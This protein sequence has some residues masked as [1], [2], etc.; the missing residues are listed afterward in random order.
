MRRARRAVVLAVGVSALALTAAATAAASA[1][2]T[3]RPGQVTTSPG[4]TTTLA[5]TTVATTTVAPSTT[6]VPTTEPATTTEPVSTTTTTTAQPVTTSDDDTSVPWGWII[7]ILAALAVVLVVVLVFMRRSSNRAKSEW[8]NAAAS[9]LRDADLTRDMLADEARPG[10]AEDARRLH[11]SPRRGR[12]RREPVRP[13]RDERTERRDATDLDLLGDVPSRLFLR[14]GVRADAAR[15]SRAP[16]CRPARHRGRHETS[17]ARLNSR[18]PLLRFVP[19]PSGVIPR[20][21]RTRCDTARRSGGTQP[22]RQARSGARRTPAFRAVRCCVLLR[23]RRRRSD[24]RH[25]SR[26]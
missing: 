2:H 20:R 1:M 17:P 12:A 23:R 7:A 4:E 9:A 13:A 10:E 6:A 3:Q 19:T 18:R 22:R 15:R 26:R 5:P 8:K 25:R 24:R 16:Y 14:P 21:R 11:R